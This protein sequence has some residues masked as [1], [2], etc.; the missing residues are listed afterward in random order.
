MLYVG[1]TVVSLGIK[2]ASKNVLGGGETVYAAS[3]EQGDACS[4]RIRKRPFLSGKKWAGFSSLS[5][6]GI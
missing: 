6:V 1:E 2:R 3:R 5:L 4:V